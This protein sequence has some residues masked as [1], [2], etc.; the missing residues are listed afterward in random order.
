MSKG[1]G[2]GA[3]WM[4][5][6]VLL[7][8]ARTP[9]Q[10]APA[11]LIERLGLETHGAVEDRVGARIHE[12]EKTRGISLGETRLQL[13]VSRFGDDSTLRIKADFLYD[14]VAEDTNTD[15]ETG[16]GWVDLREANVAFSPA[17]FMDIKAGRQILTWGTGDLLFLNDLFPKDWQAFFLGRDKDYL[18][19]PSD[20][21]FISLFPVFAGIDLA[22]SPQFDADRHVRG[23][24]L[25]YWNPQLGRRAGLDAVIE[26]D[27]PDAWFRD[28]E[29]AL[30]ISRTFGAYETALYGYRGFWKSPAGMD[31]ASFRARFPDLRVWG[32]SVRGPLGPGI[33][34]LEA[35]YYDSREDGSGNDPFVPNG[36]WRF[37]AGYEWELARELTAGVQYYVEWMQDYAAYERSLPPGSRADD[38]ADH[39]F[40]LRLTRLLLNQDLVA[41]LFLRYSLS[42]QDAYVRPTVSYRINDDMEA[43]V[44]ANIF[45]GSRDYTFL[46]QFEKNTNAYASL[47]YSF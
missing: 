21:L 27:V 5:V 13:E 43:A 41:T 26:P 33:G 2:R 22:Y 9:A 3:G 7:A 40:T 45:A 28:G 35:A 25:S 12:D 20:A 42:E 24:R 14:A 23:E 46:G 31:P 38:E 47:R 17:E 44:G 1:I 4:L 36:E 30:R 16:K 10:E 29:L 6:V 8:G 32:G 34:N 18:K 37:L 11:G 39:T 15:L 19:A